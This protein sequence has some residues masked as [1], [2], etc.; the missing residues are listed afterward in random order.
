MLN[1]ARKNP[2]NDNIGQEEDS[3]Y[4]AFTITRIQVSARYMKKSN[5]FLRTQLKHCLK[6]F[7]FTLIKYSYNADLNLDLF[8]LVF[9]NQQC[10][11]I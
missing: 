7:F 2:I 10:I 1:M 8:K 3:L 9:I 5:N 6:S 4:R 11:A